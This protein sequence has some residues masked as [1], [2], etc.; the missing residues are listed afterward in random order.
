MLASPH[1]RPHH[2]HGHYLTACVRCSPHLMS[3][4]LSK[5]AQSAFAAFQP[6]P[7]VVPTIKFSEV[8]QGTCTW[9]NKT[10]NGHHRQSTIFATC[11]TCLSHTGQHSQRPVSCSLYSRCDMSFILKSSSNVMILTDI[12]IIHRSHNIPEW[13]PLSLMMSSHC[14]PVDLPVE[15]KWPDR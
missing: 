4:L 3:H 8:A 15:R 9:V 2:D 6:F 14:P 10:T 12:L 7:E 11:L 5:I 1:H 13:F